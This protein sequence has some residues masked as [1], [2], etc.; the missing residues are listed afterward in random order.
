MQEIWKKWYP[1]SDVSGG[2]YIDSVCDDYINGFVVTLSKEDNDQELLK[3]SFPD[4]VESYKRTDETYYCE[5][6][7]NLDAQYGRAFYSDWIFFQVEHSDYLKNLSKESY[8]ISDTRN[9]KHFV[10]IAIDSTLDIINTCE[11]KVEIIYAHKP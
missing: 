9:L 1:T 4:S 3:I 8:G 5:F 11:P 10:I 6:L 2:F 7:H